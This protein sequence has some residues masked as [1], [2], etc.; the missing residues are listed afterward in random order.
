MN[1]GHRKAYNKAIK[2]CPQKA[3]VGLGLAIA[4]LLCGRYASERVLC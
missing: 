1:T 3:W 4:R 2:N